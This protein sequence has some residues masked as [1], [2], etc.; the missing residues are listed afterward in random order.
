VDLGV[1]DLQGRK[2]ATLVRGTLEAGNYTHAWNGLDDSGRSA[3]S[4]VYFYRLKVGAETYTLRGIK[5]N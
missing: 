2:V 1:F 4:G 3:G 5:L